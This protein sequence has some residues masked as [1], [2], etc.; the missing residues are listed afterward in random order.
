MELVDGLIEVRPFITV[1][2]GILDLFLLLGI[3]F[4]MMASQNIVGLA[5][6]AL[7]GLPPATRLLAGTVSLVGGMAPP[8]PG[9]RSSLTPAS[10]TP[11]RSV[12]PP[13]RWA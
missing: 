10:P 8:S 9:R 1:T 7:A 2:L 11:R 12:S 5:I 6:A 3:S 4:A 13:P